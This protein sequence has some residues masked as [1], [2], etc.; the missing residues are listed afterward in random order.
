M[1]N[2]TPH[3]VYL[4]GT[5]LG[6]EI[7]P[8]SD[9]WRLFGPSLGA[10]SEREWNELVSSIES[11]R[12]AKAFAA[13]RIGNVSSPSTTIP[14]AKAKVEIRTSPKGRSLRGE[15]VQRLLAALN[16]AV[17]LTI[18]SATTIC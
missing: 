12:Q 3:H 16:E 6:S 4:W 9:A 18:L 17:A 8:I 14:L 7:T 2:N 11:L 10:A 1:T 15:E 13:V 5:Y